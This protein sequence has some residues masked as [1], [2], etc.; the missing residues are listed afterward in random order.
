MVS[1]WGLVEEITGLIRRQYNIG[2]IVESAS[3]EGKG[4]YQRILFEGGTNLIPP[5]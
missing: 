2:L 5:T 1:I 4:A 3:V